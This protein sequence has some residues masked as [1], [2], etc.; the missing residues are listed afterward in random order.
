MQQN[1]CDTFRYLALE[2]FSR[3]GRARY[4][5][6]QPL[7]ETFTDINLLE[8][9]YRHPNNIY[10]QTFT[11]PQEGK[12]GADWE[13]WLTDANETCWLGLR[14]QA[15]V[16]HLGTNSFAHL[17]YKSGTA[18]Q[19]T[20]LK[21]AAAADG[22]VPLY[23]FYTDV[24]PNVTGWRR[25]D[26]AE[27]YG[28]SLATVEHIEGLRKEGGIKDFASVLSNAMPW[29]W[30][31]CNDCI[32]V[33]NGKKLTLPEKAWV[34]LGNQEPVSF[35]LERHRDEWVNDYPPSPGVRAIPP[36]Y[37]RRVMEGLEPE[38]MP[39]DIRG[40]LVVKEPRSS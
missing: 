30:L 25:F 34:L 10:C 37:V 13:W 28:C 38:G 3:I 32:N 4:S 19:T 9:M 22:L 26:S 18:Y 29:H 27:T 36:G 21:R 8:L 17:H 31:V 7:E 33:F 11:K 24:P 1:L 2:T 15:K 35:S 23:C 5:R 20:K 39:Y 16:L 40:I 6:H 14:V 12:N